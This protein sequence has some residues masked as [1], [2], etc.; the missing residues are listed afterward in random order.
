MGR[1]GKILVAMASTSYCQGIYNYAATLAEA[2]DAEI[3]VASIINSRDVVAVR[4][5]A[6]MGYA[7]DGDNYVT[8]V[9]DLRKQ[10][11]DAIIRQSTFP[12]DRVQVILKVGNPVDELLK[13]VV[14]EA[15]DMVVMGTKGRT[16]LEQMLTGSVAEKM[17]R[18]SPVTVVSYRDEVQAERLRK[19]IHP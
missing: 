19:R 6:D 8:G 3:V 14:R 7:V 9:K 5:I 17:F 2:L 1:I 18:K 16:D 4:Q 10:D 15:V 12:R 13:I 11:I